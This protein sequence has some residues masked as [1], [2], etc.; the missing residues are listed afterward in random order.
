MLLAA[1]LH[2]WNVAPKNTKS[3][4]FAFQDDFAQGMIA[5]IWLTVFA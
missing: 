1:E 5:F 2:N 4:K 3:I